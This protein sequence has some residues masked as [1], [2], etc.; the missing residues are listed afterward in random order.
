MTAFRSRLLNSLGVVEILTHRVGLGGVLVQDVQLQLIRPPVRV[1]W[2]SS[3]RVCHW[4]LGFVIHVLSDAGF[5][6]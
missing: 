2:G 4:A 6:F 1:R 3:D 5:A